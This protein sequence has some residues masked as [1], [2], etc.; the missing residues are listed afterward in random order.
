M[1]PPRKQVCHTA[2]PG[3]KL[4]RSY[5]RRVDQTR[6]QKRVSAL[7]GDSR[8]ARRSRFYSATRKPAGEFRK[9][10]ATWVAE[11]LHGLGSDGGDAFPVLLD[12]PI[13]QILLLRH[14]MPVR[15]KLN[16]FNR[17]IEE[18]RERIAAV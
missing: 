18:N 7:C 13:K 11:M 10:I 17:E 9:M 6:Q 15:M 2:Y 8:L 5:A 16:L 12:F 14:P 1:R 3:A 4:N